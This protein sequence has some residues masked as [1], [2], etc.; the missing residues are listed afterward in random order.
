MIIIKTEFEEKPEK[1]S[2]CRFLDTPS[3]YSSTYFCYADKEHRSL[4]G[5]DTWRPFWCPLEEVKEN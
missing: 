2:D 1:C 3:E 4:G 5:Y